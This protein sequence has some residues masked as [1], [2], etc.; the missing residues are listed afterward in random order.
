MTYTHV[1]RYISVPPYII[2]TLNYVC[3]VSSC[4]AQHVFIGIYLTDIFIL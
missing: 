1:R 4:T 2:D 3:D